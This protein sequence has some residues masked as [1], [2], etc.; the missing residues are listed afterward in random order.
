VPVAE[1]CNEPMLLAVATA[2][3]PNAYTQTE[4]LERFAITDPRTSSVFL[5]SH[6]DRRNLYLGDLSADRISAETQGELLDKHLAGA[7]DM[8]SRAIM[9]CL[10]RAGLEPEDVGF[11]CCV[12]TTGFL[13]PGLSARFIHEL[14]LRPDTSRIDVVGMGCN[15]GLN[16]LNPVV[17]W[18]ARNPGRYALQLCVEV[19]SA[20]YVYDGGMR[21]TV[22]NALF[23][24]G[25]AAVLVGDRRPPALPVGPLPQVLT[26]G[27]HVLTEALGAMR[28]DWDGDQSKYSFFLDPLIPYVV[29][30]N[31]ARPVD[32]LLKQ[33]AL[34]RREIDHWVV[35]TG[36]KKVIDGLKYNLDLTDHDLR[37]TRSVLREHGNV[38]SASF[39]FS[40]ERLVD[41]DAPRAGDLGLMMTMGPGTTIEAV[42]LQW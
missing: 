10:K 37:H 7:L 39:L 20:A 30:A 27:S 42:L 9:E 18:S 21:T 19:C 12:T 32:D 26:F 23:G 41:E 8:G 28:F 34:R 22:V 13:C 24:D 33:H 16:G 2:T 29:G 15:A 3:P 40:Y 14:G 6:I 4:I 1:T 17:A 5:N 25:A 38:S 11:L 35:H 31:A 36:G